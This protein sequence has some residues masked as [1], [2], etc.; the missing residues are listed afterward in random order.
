MEP[1]WL[2]WRDVPSGRKSFLWDEVKKYFQFPHGTEAKAKEYT[3]KQLGFSY[4]KWKTELTNKYLKNNLTPFEEYGKIT[5]A[6]WDEFV[7]QRTTKEAIQRSAA[8]SALAKTDRHKPHLGPGGYAAKVEQWL[9]ERED[10]IAK[11]L[12]DPYEGLNERTYLRVKGREVKV[13]GGEKGF[14][15][16]ETA[17]VV[18]RIKFW[19]EKEKEG[20]F[21]SDREKDCLTRGLGTKEHGGQVRGLSSKKNWKQGF[22]EDIHKYKKHDRY[23][24][25][26]RETAKE[27]FMEEIKTMF[28]QGKFDI[29]GL[30][31]VFDGS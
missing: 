10:L 25:E 14:A 3:L 16:P 6:Q 28:T 30:P 26:M 8:N 21:V 31:A 13:P 4:R 5:P 7:R 27:V 20:K 22:S 23:K 17:E 12:P 1:T 15:K 19:A 2:D 24:Q 18:K 9:K 29:P 11:G